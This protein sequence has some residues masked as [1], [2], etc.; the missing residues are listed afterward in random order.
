MNFC[1]FGFEKGAHGTYL[2]LGGSVWKLAMY[3]RSLRNLTCLAS[4]CPNH[5][6]MC[7]VYYRQLQGDVSLDIL[8]RHP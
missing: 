7:Q 1:R 5:C 8:A 2:V 6:S 4:A 3:A